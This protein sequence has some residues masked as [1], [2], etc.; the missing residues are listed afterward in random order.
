MENQKVPN[1]VKCQQC[2]AETYMPFK[3]NYCGQLFCDEH[4][5]PENHDCPE[6]LKA[7]APKEQPTVKTESW[8]RDGFIVVPP[9]RR[10]RLIWFS[11]TELKHLLIGVLLTLAIGFSM[12][13]YSMPWLYAS[14]DVLTALAVVFAFSFI[15]HEIAHKITAQ[16]YGLW[17]EFRMTIW[18]ALI[19]LL[20]IISPFKIISPGAVMVG[21][22]ADKKTIGKT[23]IAGPLTNIALTL[24]F[25]LFAQFS[26][27]LMWFVFAFG[28]LI[29]SFIALFNLIPFGILD[30]FKVFLWNKAIWAVV[31]S[32]SVVLTIYSYTIF[33]MV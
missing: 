17:A 8:Y 21:G 6:Y 27:D 24:L 14:P 7:R 5:L 28:V 4:R 22:M 29:N 9:R 26:Q 3:C 10:G 16:N 1:K 18:G 2:G 11:T 12:P 30:G 15:I 23:S 33:P 20:S 32:A 13:L 25:L 31:F 19:T